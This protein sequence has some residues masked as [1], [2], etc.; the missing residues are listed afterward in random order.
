M[1]EILTL[2]FPVFNFSKVFNYLDF[3]LKINHINDT[4]QT[5]F[6][7]AA[8]TYVQWLWPPCVKLSWLPPTWFLRSPL[9]SLLPAWVTL[10]ICRRISSILERLSCSICWAVDN[11]WSCMT[12]HQ[13]TIIPTSSRNFLPDQLGWKLVSAHTH[14]KRSNL[15]NLKRESKSTLLT[16]IKKKT[17]PR[18]EMSEW[19]V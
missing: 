13:Q 16:V 7:T 18:E 3:L 8:D 6:W 11:I 2:S 1:S 19:C 5:H 17:R 9:P 12:T 14:T 15:N 4:L 10:I